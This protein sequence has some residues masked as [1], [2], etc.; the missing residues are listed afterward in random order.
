MAAL[1]TDP[2][3]PSTLLIAMLDYSDYSASRGVGLGMLS[4]WHYIGGG[5]RKDMA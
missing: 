1:F 3:W 2:A 5:E 4:P